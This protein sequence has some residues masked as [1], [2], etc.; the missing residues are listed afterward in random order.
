ML[1][2]QGNGS[3]GSCVKTNLAIVL[4]QLRV[5]P[6]SLKQEDSKPRFIYWR[7]IHRFPESIRR[8]FGCDDTHLFS[9]LAPEWL[10]RNQEWDPQT[11]QGSPYMVTQ[12]LWTHVNRGRYVIPDDIRA[13]LSETLRFLCK[14]ILCT[15]HF[16]KFSVALRMLLITSVNG[17]SGGS[18]FS[19]LKL[20]KT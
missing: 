17:A 18:R 11:L 12:I 19:K 14:K 20:L 13:L 15:V 7:C 4:K 9:P 5:S 6:F 1:A 16:P 10:I 8:F 3:V 2:C